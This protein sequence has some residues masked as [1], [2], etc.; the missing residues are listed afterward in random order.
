MSQYIIMQSKTKYVFG[1]DPPLRTFFLQVHDTTRPEEEQITVW[2]GATP[3]TEIHEV[4]QLVQMAS[5]HDLDMPYR[6][7]VEL[8]EDKDQNR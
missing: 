1:W 6:I 5:E 8:E 7:Q 3:E 2:L 4:E